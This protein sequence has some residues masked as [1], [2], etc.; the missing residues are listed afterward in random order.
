MFEFEDGQVVQLA[1]VGCVVPALVVG[2]IAAFSLPFHSSD[3]I[4][5]QA[6]QG[7]PVSV[8]VQGPVAKQRA[9]PNSIPPAPGA[10]L[11]PV[12]MSA[13]GRTA[14][15][16]EDWARPLSKASGVDGQAFSA[17]ANAAAQAQIRWPECSLKWTTLAG[18]GWVE[19]KHGTYNG[20]IFSGG[21]RLDEDGVAQPLIIGPALDGNGFAFIED[22][23]GGEHDGDNLHDRAIGPMQFIPESW[24]IFGLDADGDGYANPHQIDDAALGAA[25]LLCSGGRD[26]SVAGDWKDAIFS[27]NQSEEYLK[28]VRDAANKYAS[29]DF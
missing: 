26:L 17:Y 29:F 6:G 3:S 8:S 19:S 5:E 13:G 4:T 15:V 16:F 20:H 27:Y 10:S 24:S 9:V 1:A 22:T 12:D 21:S 28:D 25:N 2:A 7:S 11:P 23:D 14:Q 18:L